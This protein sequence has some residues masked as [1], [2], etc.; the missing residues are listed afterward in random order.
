[1]GRDKR[2]CSPELYYLLTNRTIDGTF[3]FRPDDECNRIIG[4]VLARA[5]S[6][7]EVDLVC[8]TFL[9]NHFHLIARFPH[10]NMAE[11]MRDLQ[12]G[13]AR[14]IN[15]LRDERV[16]PV[17][18]ARYDD[19]VLL[20][21]AVL[22]EKIS[23]VVNN[24]VKDGLVV[25]PSAWPG[26]HS[27]RCHKEGVRWVGEW[28]DAA[29]WHNVSRRK[30]DQDPSC[31]WRTYSVRLHIPVCLPGATRDDRREAMLE[32]IETDC[33]ALRRQRTL[34]RRPRPPKVW[35][36][37]SWRR[38]KKLNNDKRSAPSPLAIGSC[39]EK[40]REHI[41]MRRRLNA[42]YQRQLRRSWDGKSTQ[43]PTGTHPPACN[44]CMNEEGVLGLPSG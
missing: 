12:F 32:R 10:R 27:H 39:A 44:R 35:V 23:Y 30:G 31:A 25:H 3:L 13:I 5:A 7:H 29:H 20:D 38:T 11:F 22:L 21:E 41:N 24:P 6:I 17:F 37:M 43:Y 15:R 36:G 16:G 8:F 42:K 19:E 33:S 1:M 26:V 9:S 14:R 18:E 2:Y 4:G 28:F 40:V 34:H